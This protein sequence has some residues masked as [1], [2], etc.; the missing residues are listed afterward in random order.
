LIKPTKKLN[1]YYFANSKISTPTK[2]V[3]A[4]ENRL[5]NPKEIN[6]KLL[7]KYIQLYSKNKKLLKRHSDCLNMH[8]KKNFS[9]NKMFLNLEKIYKKFL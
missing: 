4:N 8:A 3:S 5:I 2:V 7:A 9:I 1:S 6:P